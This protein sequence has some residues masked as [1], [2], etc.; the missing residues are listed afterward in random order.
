MERHVL[1]GHGG[2]DTDPAYTPPG[3]E[4]V[5]IPQGTTIQF[6][7]DTNQALTYSSRQLDIWEQIQAP[8]P[9]LDSRDVTY[10]LTLQSNEEGWAE[11]LANDPQF[12]GCQVFLPGRNGVPDSVRL[13]GGTPATCPTRP[14]QVAAGMTH[15]CDGIL[16]TLRGRLDWVACT[17]VVF[18]KAAAAPLERA[19]A[20]AVI[21]GR[22]HSVILGGDPDWVPDEA[23]QQVIARANRAQL[24]NR[25]DGEVVGYVL[26][27][28][29]LLLGGLHE[30]HHCDYV[31]KQRQDTFRGT[32]T[33]RTDAGGMLS[34]LEISDVPLYKREIVRAALS[35]F[36]D[37]RPVFT[38]TR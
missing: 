11:E 17:S 20:N 21:K 23:D 7:C 12:A 9:P 6:Y 19:A 32:V 38:S 24:E 2:L 16:G 18:P 35:L 36:T 34:G 3:M 29:A 22:S 27:G 13:C 10:N 4:I 30:E 31:L 26:G 33:V 25:G 8:F 5:A 28:F 15:G 37:A 1:L 14:D